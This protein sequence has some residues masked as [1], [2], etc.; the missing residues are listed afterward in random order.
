MTRI[1]DETSTAI[2]DEDGFETVKVEKL[3]LKGEEK[4]GVDFA[5]FNFMMSA[6]FDDFN[7]C[8]EDET[9]SAAHLLEK[10]WELFYPYLKAEITDKMDLSKKMN[11]TVKDADATVNMGFQIKFKLDH[12]EMM[13]EKYGLIKAY[14]ERLKIQEK[15]LIERIDKLKKEESIK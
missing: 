9:K 13:L 5:H 15:K 11:E 4:D 10:F 7:A 14:R 3:L 8:M 2:M 1:N 12:A 6:Y